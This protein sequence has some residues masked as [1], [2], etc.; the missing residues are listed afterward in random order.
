MNPDCEC[1]TWARS[2]CRVMWSHNPSCPKYDP[3]GDAHKLLTALRKGIE[4]WARD[5]D[6]VHEDCWD[7]YEQLRG[8]LGD[9]VRNGETE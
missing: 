9:P 3:D 7:A 8:M 2:D 1:R 6:G 4:S 5:C